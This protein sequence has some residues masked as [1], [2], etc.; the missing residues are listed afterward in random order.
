[1]TA[2]GK[3]K[4]TDR[5]EWVLSAL[6]EFEGRLT[7]YAA[8][9]LHDENLAC[10]AVQHTFLR[11]CDASQDELDGRLASWLFTVCRNKSLDMIRR[12]GRIESLV[13]D[14]SRLLGEDTDPAE[15]AEQAD[16]HAG[17]RRLVDRLP[18]SQREAIDLWL[19]GFN[20]TEIAEIT[21]RSNGAARVL[22]H[23]ALMQLREHPWTQRLLS[24]E[25]QAKV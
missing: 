15:A 2:N 22:V 25:Q 21:E 19:E 20:Y 23:R 6:D 5:R 17:L 16:V 18:A 1:M 10:D 12:N 14:E 24:E 9:L 7:R 4:K 13:N 11:L 8:R 3:P